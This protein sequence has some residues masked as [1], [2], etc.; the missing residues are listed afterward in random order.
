LHDLHV[1]VHDEN[2]P[3]EQIKNKF[4]VNLTHNTVTPH[5]LN[6]NYRNFLIR[7]QNSVF[8]PPLERLQNSP[9]FL[10]SVFPENP[11]GSRLKVQLFPDTSIC[12]ETDT[13]TDFQ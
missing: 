11:G 5:V 12:P 6:F 7:A 1:H 10:C 9:G 3:E 4:E 13:F 2:E 8:Y